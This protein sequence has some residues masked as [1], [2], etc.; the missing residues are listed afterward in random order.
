MIWAILF[1]VAWAFLLLA[2]FALIA[3][4]LVH[5][6]MT[7]AHSH[8]WSWGTWRDFHREFQK[9]SWRREQPWQDSYFCFSTNSRVHASIVRFGGRGMVLDPVSLWRVNRWIRADRG[10]VKVD[11]RNRG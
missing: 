1:A 2:W 4:W 3:P 7:R 8:G 10:N 11:W 5:R 9:Y 6:D